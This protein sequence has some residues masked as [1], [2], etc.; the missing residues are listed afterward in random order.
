MTGQ[1]RNLQQGDGSVMTATPFNQTD[2]YQ[3]L[4]RTPPV[5]HANNNPGFMQVFRGIVGRKS[6]AVLN[7]NGHILNLVNLDILRDGHSELLIYTSSNS[8]GVPGVEFTYAPDKKK[9]NLGRAR[10]A[11][12]KVQKLNRIRSI[13]MAPIDQ[14]ME[15][16]VLFGDTKWNGIYTSNNRYFF[17]ANG[18]AEVAQITLK[19]NNPL[20][21]GWF[22]MHVSIR[23]VPQEVSQQEQPGFLSRFGKTITDGI[24]SI[25]QGHN[26]F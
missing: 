24:R 16:Q 1:D 3:N 18:A 7:T 10:Q 12:D 5:R 26:P 19:C 11:I 2:A 13:I 22:N 25:S 4:F 17:R 6:Q 15:M 23:I 21:P 20:N 8:S 9:P 14:T